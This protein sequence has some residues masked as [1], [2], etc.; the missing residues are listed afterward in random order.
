MTVMVPAGS[1]DFPGW[2]RVVEVDGWCRYVGRPEEEVGMMSERVKG[3]K[4]AASECHVS[5]CT[6]TASALGV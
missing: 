5:S 1:R 4:Q 2:N 3:A 6:R